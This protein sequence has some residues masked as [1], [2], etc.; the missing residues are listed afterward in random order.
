[1]NTIPALL[2]EMTTEAREK[3]LRLL[4]R[5]M[6]DELD[7]NGYHEVWDEFFAEII[8]ILNSMDYQDAFGTEGWRKTFLGIDP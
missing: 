1:M 2:S 6:I 4:L 8:P 3:Y 5:G 7:C